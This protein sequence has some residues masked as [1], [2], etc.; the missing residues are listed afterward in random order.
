MKKFK[1][2]DLILYLYKE[3]SPAIQKAVDEALEEGDIELTEQLAVLERSIRQLDQ[4]KM[5]S[6]SKISIKTIMDHAHAAVKKK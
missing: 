3:C 2:E 4:L 5:K 1:E 6:P